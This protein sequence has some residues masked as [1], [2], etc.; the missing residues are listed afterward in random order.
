MFFHNRK[1]LNNFKRYIDRDDIKYYD[2]GIPNMDNSLLLKESKKEKIITFFS[3]VQEIYTETTLK[4]V[5]SVL[6]FLISKGYRI[7]VKDRK[8]KK[9]EVYRQ[10]I[11]RSL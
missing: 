10:E 4:E 3:P 6:L 7:L 1:F 8:G 2:F 9:V 11:K 5:E